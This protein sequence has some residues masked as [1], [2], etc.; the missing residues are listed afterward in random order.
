MKR[1][2][3]LS[4]CLVF[5]VLISGCQPKESGLFLIRQ[6][7]LYGFINKTGKIVIKPQFEE[8]ESFSE[9]LAPVMID[10]K[11]GYINKTGKTV[12]EPQ[13]DDVMGSFSAGPSPLPRIGGL[14]LL[15]PYFLRRIFALFRSFFN[16]MFSCILFS[17]KFI[18]HEISRS[19]R[20]PSSFMTVI[21]VCV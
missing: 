17:R 11:Y 3:S 18:P 16:S 14:S 7:D 9:G 4:I 13:Y 12:I 19:P 2:F 5:L 21:S 1:V 8:A 20:I 10:K 15:R 6:N